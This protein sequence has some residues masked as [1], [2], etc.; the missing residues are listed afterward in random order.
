VQ[1]EFQTA[2][3][4]P[5]R[6]QD[7]IIAMVAEAVMTEL[8]SAP[9]FPDNTEINREFFD[10][11][12]FSAIPAPNRQATSIAYTGP[13]VVSRPDVVSTSARGRAFA[14]QS[15]FLRGPVEL[16]ITAGDARD[17]AV[18]QYRGH[19]VVLQSCRHRAC[20]RGYRTS[21]PVSTARSAAWSR[22]RFRASASTSPRI[23]NVAPASQ[24]CGLRCAFG[25][26]R[27]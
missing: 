16:R 17:Q 27:Q 20:G 2:G 8:V 18:S 14:I 12:P 21:D 5:L 3:F 19:N 7:L 25:S 6:S 4:R 22:P 13:A 10:F 9:Q 1:P 23:S 24:A 26:A 11:G 15:S